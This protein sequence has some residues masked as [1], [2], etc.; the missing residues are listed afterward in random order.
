MGAL[1]VPR[2]HYHLLMLKRDPMTGIRVYVVGVEH[3]EVTSESALLG[4][5]R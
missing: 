3:T 5:F 4:A 2:C 1:R